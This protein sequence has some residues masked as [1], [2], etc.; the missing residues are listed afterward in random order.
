[1]GVFNPVSEE[2]IKK[3]RGSGVLVFIRFNSEFDKNF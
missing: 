1:M 2:R 3:D